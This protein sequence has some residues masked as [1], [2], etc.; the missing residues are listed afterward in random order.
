[1]QIETARLLLREFKRT[2]WED[3]HQ[4]CKDPEVY[5]Y[6]EWGPNSVEDTMNFVDSTLQSQRSK[7]RHTYELAVILK[8]SGDFIGGCGLRVHYADVQQGDIGYCYNRKYWRNGYGAEA[9]GALLK[10][11]FTDLKLH[12]IHATC[13]AENAGSAAVLKK[14]GM[15]QE[16]HFL[17]DKLVKGRW[18][19][20]LLFAIL[21][22]EWERRQKT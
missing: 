22:D 2:D 14:S 10:M 13:D 4:Y 6:M 5:K 8:E 20:T 9:C 15:R 7:P 19:D 18:R 17:Q 21:R 12:R 1:M 11:G 16:A 3:V